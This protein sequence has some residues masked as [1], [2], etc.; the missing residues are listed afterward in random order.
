MHVH[1][2]SVIKNLARHNRGSLIPV[3]VT[4]KRNG[5][6]PCLV[7]QKKTMT[8]SSN[9]VQTL[10]TSCMYIVVRSRPNHF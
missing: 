10:P 6:K 1:M 4:I 7:K 3:H 8:F 2:Y 9:L 5:V